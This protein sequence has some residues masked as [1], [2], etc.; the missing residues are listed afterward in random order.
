MEGWELVDEYVLLEIFS[1]LDLTAL[2]R[3]GA[4]CW[5]WYNVASDELL[6]KHLVLRR[7]NTN[8]Q[9]RITN[10]TL[11]PSVKSFKLELKRLHWSTPDPN[12]PPESFKDHGEEVNH[13]SFSGDGQYFATV[14]EDSLVIVWKIE[15]GRHFL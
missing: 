5:R 8:L 1:Y 10:I 3:V 12:I 6:W 14:S 9:N 13:V 2:G 7:L 15:E 4:V 11:P